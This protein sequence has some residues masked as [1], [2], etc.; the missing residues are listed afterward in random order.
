MNNIPK[1]SII[2]GDRRFSLMAELFAS[3]RQTVRT[4]FLPEIPGTDTLPFH[5]AVAT[6]DRIV[7]PL[8]AA[9]DG[10]HI[11]VCAEF[12]TRAGLE[13]TQIPTLYELQVRLKKGQTVLGGMLPA[14]FVRG[15]GQS[16]VTVI[17]YFQS[18]QLTVRNVIPTVE[19][20]L[21]LL[22]AHT[23]TT[24]HGMRILVTGY[25]RI[26]KVLCDYLKNMGV[27][28]VCAARKPADLAWM[29]LRGIESAVYDR[30]PSMMRR[31][32][33][34]VNTVPQLVIDESLLQKSRPDCLFIDLASR[35]GGIDFEAAARLSRKT[36]HALSLPG[37]V[38]PQSAAR[39]LYDT[40]ISL[41]AD[42]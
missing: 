11:N 12:L 16:G 42:A 4:A 3:R 13:I 41:S 37:K 39:Y 23:D 1:W 17:D 18:E 21:A 2:G 31:F 20:C 24:L 14:W 19:G 36:L 22:M 9:V 10:A 29:Q 27:Q 15:C 30:L 32:D 6:A 38:A 8:P 35:P 26:G 40:I 25:G 34:V 5:E 7:L 28:V 33:A